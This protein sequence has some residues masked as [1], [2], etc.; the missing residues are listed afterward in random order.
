MQRKALVLIPLCLGGGLKNTKRILAQPL[1][2]YYSCKRRQS[3]KPVSPKHEDMH[4]TMIEVWVSSDRSYGSRRLCKALNI[5]GFDIG[6]YKTRRLMKELGLF[7][8]HRK[9]FK[10]TTNSKHTKPVFENLLNRKF[11]AEEADKA[12]ISDITYI[13]TEE[14]WLYLAVVIDLYSRKVV[15]RSMNT[16]MT[17]KIVCDA[18]RMAIFQRRPKP[19]LIHHSDRGGSI[20]E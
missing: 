10:V 20:C 15:G 9:K 16:R 14:G 13:W 4:Q 18:L 6:R 12:Y 17:A 8:R 2:A 5:L 19:G 3:E 1:K 7:V 11:S